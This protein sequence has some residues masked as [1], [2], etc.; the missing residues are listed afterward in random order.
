MPTTHHDHINGDHDTAQLR[1]IPISYDA[2]DCDASAKALIYALFPDWETTEG[3]VEFE[4][5]KEGITNSVSL[6]C[7]REVAYI[8]LRPIPSSSKR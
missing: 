3:P 7:S 8:P 4:R 6:H 2:T 1:Y 5:F